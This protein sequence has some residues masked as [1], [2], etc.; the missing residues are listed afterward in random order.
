MSEK[1]LYENEDPMWQIHMK[2]LMRR[3]K[4]MEIAR[5]IDEALYQYYHV[6]QGKEVPNWRYIKD[7]DWWI[8]YLKSLGIDPRNP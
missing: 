6:E 1:N 2:T 7:Q 5:T 4:S 8:E 3:K